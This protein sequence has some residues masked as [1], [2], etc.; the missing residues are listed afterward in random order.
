MSRK[1]KPKRL[2]KVASEFN[3]ST[4]SIV[5][6]LSDE[7][8][9]ID[10][11]PNSKITP[12]MYEALEEVYGVDKAK[13]QEHEKAK[14]EYE[15]R[16]SQIRAS[17]N[18]SVS[19]EDYLEPLEED[20]PLEPE[21]DEEVEGLKPQD[22]S[23]DDEEEIEGLEPEED[24]I[25]EETAD[26]E[27]VTEDEESDEEETQAEPDEEVEASEEEAE[28]AEAEEETQEAE[29][30]AEAQEETADEDDSEEEQ[31]A[32][33]E[34]Q[35]EESDEEE[36]GDDEEV[37]AK[38]YETEEVEASDA[39]YA[40]EDDSEAK[41]STDM[42]AKEAIAHIENTP[43]EELE[44]FVPEDEDRVTVQRALDDKKENS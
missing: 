13:S 5:D 11:K 23:E 9:E 15:S 16:R 43:L 38:E 10:N 41:V 7:G 36:D 42:L 4:T 17:R 28:T 2:F 8:F 30:T 37:E 31:E 39:E 40:E 24:D 3:V 12:E 33:A 27:A 6:S 32:A 18:E 14:E 22:E 34:A 1:A 26:E 19:V 25:S 21:D 20:M 29:D 35:D 44:G